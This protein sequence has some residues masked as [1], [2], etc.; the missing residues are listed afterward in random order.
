IIDGA[1]QRAVELESNGLVAEFETLPPMCED[2]SLAIE[3]TKILSDGLE[4]AHKEHG[5]KTCLRVTPNDLREMSR[6]PQMRGGSLFERML[7]TFEG[8]AK[9]GGELLSI[10][11]TGGKELH[12]EYLTYCDLN[13]VIF[14]QAILGVRDM[15]FLWTEISKIAKKTGTFAAG[16][17]ACGFGNTAMVLAEKKY[18]P[19]TF[20]SVVRAISAVRALPAHECG[21]V[22]PGKDCAYENVYLKA[23]TG[24]PMAME[25][26]SAACAHLSP[27]GN[28]A[29]AYCD[30]WSNES[31]QN[32][33]LLAAMAPTC[34]TEQ[35]IYDCRLMNAATSE[36]KE[37]ARMLRNLMVKSDA[38]IDPQAFI[39][40]PEPVIAIS[41]AIVKA[42]THYH[43]AIAAGKTAVK[44]MRDAQTAG[45]LRIPEKDALYLDIM[46]D[47][48]AALPA[49]ESKFIDEMMAT[50]DTTKFQPKEYGL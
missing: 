42:D 41:E 3:L 48:L 30:T 49:D 46:D 25:G 10:E 26:K 40:S 11:S 16:D 13:G 27:V 31:V 21:A 29:A 15:T 32:V 18:I 39:L 23:I 14:S 4:K 12:D 22:G 9:A 37:T 34:Y 47:T 19:R 5:L 35:L 6:P 33:K 43:A 44:L 7:E 36:G 20:A 28:I 2:P 17:S 38:I 1:A 50:A 8:C 45:K 24:Y